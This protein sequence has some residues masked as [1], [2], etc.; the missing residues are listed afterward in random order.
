MSTIIQ[1]FQKLF[2]KKIQ[3]FWCLKDTINPLQL[4]IFTNVIRCSRLPLSVGHCIYFIYPSIFTYQFYL[5]LSFVYK[6]V[7]QIS[8]KLFCSEDKRLSLELS[9]FY[10]GHNLCRKE[11]FP[12]YLGRKLKVQKT[13]TRFCRWKNADNNN[14]I[15]FLSLENP[16]TFLLYERKDLKT[17][18]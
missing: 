10:Q 6:T 18:F 5:Q 9:G 8:F 3:T 14:I 15:I 7:S 4:Y 13:E 12:K 11:L 2:L 1:I 16:C 17:H